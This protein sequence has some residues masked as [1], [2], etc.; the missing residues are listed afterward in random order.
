MVG[1]NSISNIHMNPPNLLS[2]LTPH[3]FPPLKGGGLPAFGGAVGDQG[4]GRGSPA[5]VLRLTR[6]MISTAMFRIE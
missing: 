2:F 3:P 4:L 5:F 1:M 6:G